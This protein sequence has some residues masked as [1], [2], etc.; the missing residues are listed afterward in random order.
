MQDHQRFRRTLNPDEARRFADELTDHVPALAT[1]LA[2]EDDLAR[3]CSDLIEK[4]NGYELPDEQ[5]EQVIACYQRSVILAIEERRE[6]PLWRA[7]REQRGLTGWRDEI[8]IGATTIDTRPGRA[9]S[10]DIDAT[11]GAGR[12]QL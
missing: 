10:V 8:E 4:L 6:D 5:A 3:F 9:I 7:M 12:V 1:Q 11:T 2:D